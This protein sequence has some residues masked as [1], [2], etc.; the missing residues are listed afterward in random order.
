MFSNTKL[1]VDKV[2][3]LHVKHGY[4]SRA[5]HIEAQMK[6]HGID[7][8]YILDGDIPD[9]NDA[10]LDKYFIDSMHNATPATSCTL[11][12]ILAYEALLLENYK[13]ALIFED[14]IF[15]NSNFNEI[16]NA[17]MHEIERRE[18]INS[19]KLFIS[20]ENSELNF[21][22]SSKLISGQFL[23]KQETGRCAGA[24]YITKGSAE[25]MISSLQQH[26]CNKISDIWH[27][28][29]FKNG[30]LDIFWC[31]PTIAEQGSHSGQFDSALSHRRKDIIRAIAW[32][33]RKKI[34]KTK[35]KIR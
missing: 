25:K 17:C 29:L 9:I 7:F 30:L 19:D 27:N 23:Y 24:Y 8:T 32:W 20:F 15:L 14:D 33:F 4:E 12:H 2:F 1:N 13:D 5:E 18:D 26:K 11:K 28:D 35:F 6:Q 22:P 10:I 21:V 31:H 3:V 34:Q 16:F